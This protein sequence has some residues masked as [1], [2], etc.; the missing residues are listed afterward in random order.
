MK[1]KG[2]EIL[3]CLENVL[4]NVAYFQNTLSNLFGTIWAHEI[5]FY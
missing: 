5:K 3:L 2:P 1:S 4:F